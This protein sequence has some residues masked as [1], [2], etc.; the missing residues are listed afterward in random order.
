M[1]AQGPVRR[2]PD[3]LAMRPVVQPHRRQAWRPFLPSAVIAAPFFLVLVISIFI[4]LG[5]A[6]IGV[7]LL[8]V[9]G[10]LCVAVL[11]SLWWLLLPGLNVIAAD[12]EGLGVR[13]NLL[14]SFVPWSVIEQVRTH[15]ATSRPEWV[16]GASFYVVSLQRSDRRLRTDV[17]VLAIGAVNTQNRRRIRAECEARGI[18][19]QGP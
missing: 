11:R 4:P 19:F 18:P 7:S 9:V 16:R 6:L 13:K 8:V 17:E 12:E 1:D 10:I 14:R 3:L 2:R 15:E 5:E